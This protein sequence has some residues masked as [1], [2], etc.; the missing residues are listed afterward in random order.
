MPNHIHTTIAFTKTKKSINKIVGDG[1]RFIGYEIVKRLKEQVRQDILL[2]LENAVNISDKKKGKL[3]EIWEDSFV[4]KAFGRKECNGDKF[5]VQKLD[6]MH[7][8]PFTG[9]W[10]LSVNA[11]EYV[12]SSARFYICG[13]QGIYPVMNYKELNDIDLNNLPA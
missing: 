7:N 1:K 6:Y 2:Q 9:K 4:P 8:N 12:H 5:I 13:E 3:N 11:I 10:Q